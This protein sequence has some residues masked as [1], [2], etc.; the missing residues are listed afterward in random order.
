MRII[1]TE[2]HDVELVDPIVEIGTRTIDDASAKTF[3]PM[4]I[5]IDSD[6]PMK[7]YAKYLPAQPYVNDTWEDK[8][9]EDAVNE[10]IKSIEIK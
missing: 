1:L 2:T 9:V 6:N 4:V 8:D 7:R 3:T 5:F 10:Y